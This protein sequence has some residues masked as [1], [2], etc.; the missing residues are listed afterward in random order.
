MHIRLL[1]MLINSTRQYIQPTPMDKLFLSYNLSCLK[2]MLLI[3]V[4]MSCDKALDV[5]II[6]VIMVSHNLKC[7]VCVSFDVEFVL[8]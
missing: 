6:E 5:I 7:K 3:F 4:L 8:I 2:I 1:C